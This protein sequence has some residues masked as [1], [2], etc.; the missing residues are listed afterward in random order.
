MT[1][2]VKLGIRSPLVASA[3]KILLGNVAVTGI[4]MLTGLLM[5][6]W[7]PPI[8]MGVWN[9]VS[10]VNVYAPFIGL[11]IYSGLSRELPVL[12]GADKVDEARIVAQAASAWAWIL[13]TVTVL[14]CAASFAIFMFRDERAVAWTI[15]A[16]GIS[17]LFGWH[18]SFLGTTYRTHSEFGRLSLANALV[19]F[20][21]LLLMIL[22]ARFGY[23]GLL[24]RAG[25]SSALAFGVLYYHRPFPV[26]PVWNRNAFVTLFKVG[27]PLFVVGHLATVFVTL[28][29]TVLVHST[30]AIG[31]F[32]LASLVGNA[33][34]MVPAAFATVA[35]PAMAQ[36]YGKSG[37]SRGLWRQAAIVSVWTVTVSGTIGWISWWALPAF[38]ER[39]LPAY[40]EGLSAARWAAFHG[41]ALGFHAFANIFNVLRRQDLYVVCLAI[42]TAVFGAA[43]FLRSAGLGVESKVLVASQAMLAGAFAF[44]SSTMAASWYACVRHDRNREAR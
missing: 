21:G 24:W 7:I 38:V 28:D 36:A 8:E 41:V 27:A 11:G 34:R 43:W 14:V 31:L 44:S 3:A 25:L 18:G 22:V 29:Q 26:R 30:K 10:L 32:T 35:F 20:I 12:I 13:G 40:L 16:V 1:D 23:W 37:E 33:V 2:G 6:R 17:L 15:T 5:A 42:G 39:L 4:Q 9:T 19:A